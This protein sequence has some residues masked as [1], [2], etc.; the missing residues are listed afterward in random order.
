MR[1]FFFLIFH[2][3]FVVHA[4]PEQYTKNSYSV[5]ESHVIGEKYHYKYRFKDHKGLFQDL[6]W[7]F[8]RWDSDSFLMNFGLNQK[9]GETFKIGRQE[10][11]YSMM[12]LKNGVVVF[13]YSKVVEESRTPVK[14]LY[15]ALSRIFQKHGIKGR[16][17][18][19][20]I[21]RFL[22][23]IPYGI[24]PTNY[25][26]RFING[27]FPPSELL[28]MGWGDCDSKSILMATLLSFEPRFY[29]RLAMV[30]VPGHALLGLELIPGPYDKTV[31]Y[32][33]RTFI[34]AEPVGIGRTPLGQTNSPYS[35]SINVQPLNLSTPPSVSLVPSSIGKNSPPTQE[36]GCPDNALL[37]KYKRAYANEVI[38]SCQ[39]KVNG[40]YLKHGPTKTFDDKGNLKSKEFFNLGT[41]I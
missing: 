40:K 13:D 12:K 29:N 8:N 41:R 16:A 11:K 9:E 1:L 33:G 24:P 23:D 36:E 15:Q 14:P 2:L 19:E 22:Q 17:K 31:R 37:V 35:R 26:G 34:Y 7:A 25:E 30:L 20:F 27:M 4:Q 6:T 38:K 10:L 39:K 5:S 32:L 21:M 28:K 3:F 18:I